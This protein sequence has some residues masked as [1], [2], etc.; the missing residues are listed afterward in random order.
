MTKDKPIEQT[1][2]H[3]ISSF[4]HYV[5]KDISVLP[6]AKDHR[7]HENND[8]L[9]DFD[10]A[11]QLSL[12]LT[13]ERCCPVCNETMT[14]MTR[15]FE[16]HINE[17]LDK[18]VSISPIGS[19]TGLD[20][21]DDLELTQELSHTS[22]DTAAAAAPTTSSESDVRTSTVALPR[23]KTT[24]KPIPGYKWLKDT[25][26]VVDAFSYGAIPGCHGY[27]LTHFHS[28]HYGGLKKSWVHGPIYCS[29]VTANLVQSQLQVGREYLHV[30]PL[31]KVTALS[32]TVKVSLI[33]ANHCP[34]SVL[35]VFDVL[36]RQDGESTWV[37]HVH[38]GDFRAN[39]KMCLHPL[40]CQNSNPPIDHLYLDT[41]YLQA[42]YSFPAQ[43]ECID[44]V[45]KVVQ[46]YLCGPPSIPSLLDQ[47]IK[48][49]PSLPMQNDQRQSKLLVVV[50]AYTIGKEKVFYAIANALQSK[51]FV[52]EQKLRVLL[53]QENP[54]LENLL[55]TDQSEAQV[56]VLPLN[57]IKAENMHAY[58]KSL[59][60]RFGILFAFK[61][62]GWAFKASQSL[63]AEMEV[64]SLALVTQPPK[65]RQVDLNLSYSSN[66]VKIYGVPYSE[67]SSFRELA[68]FI[69]SLNIQHIIPTVP[70]SSEKTQTMMEYYLEKWQREKPSAI[71]I[72][73]YPTESHW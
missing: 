27:F 15:E 40:L 4:F 7:A 35:F 17:C 45:T 65:E 51:I 52:T 33:D 2:N 61:P 30:L 66:Q 36:R 1:G 18:N 20:Q 5:P 49:T 59:A 73:P 62:T 57:D 60:P 3:L 68:S 38:T 47:W 8:S 46:G 69:A 54:D 9:N 72:V 10:Q 71:E 28:D 67:H 41:T 23:S 56:H 34:G 64:G 12:K 48:R 11:V 14:L 6:T 24:K 43:E 19:L 29:K 25:R 42:K 55:T 37:R 13:M 44:A 50:G 53:C 39:P 70:S 63:T 22:L 31:D 21:V 26:F 58:L 16:L 32:D